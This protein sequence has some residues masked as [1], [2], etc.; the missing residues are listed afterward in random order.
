MFLYVHRLTC[1]L[2]T[3]FH[4]HFRW[5]KTTKIYLICTSPF[6]QLH[7]KNTN[8]FNLQQNN[9][10]RGQASCRVA[11][12]WRQRRRPPPLGLPHLGQRQVAGS[13]ASAASS[14]CAEEGQRR[15]GR[16]LWV[17][18]EWEQHQVA[19]AWGQ[20]CGR[21][22]RCAPPQ[23]SRRAPPRRPSSHR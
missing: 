17:S 14:A 22:R 13:T 3:H 6:S 4:F 8:D 9:S 20:R 21:C 1:F 2:N 16:G 23:R 11:V 7:S 18:L 5:S 10:F 19:V 15:G 12:A